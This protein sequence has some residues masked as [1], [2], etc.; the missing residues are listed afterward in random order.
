MSRIPRLLAAALLTALLL[1]PG[2]SHAA[3]GLVPVKSGHSVKKTVKRLTS[4]LEKRGMT[5]FAVIDHADGAKRAGLELPPTTVVLFGNPGAGTP[6]MQCARTMA[7]DLPQKMLV[8][9]GP[10][11][12]GQGHG[13]T[14]I[15]YN[16]P[17]YLARRHGITGCGESLRK[18][19]EAL[20]GFARRAAGE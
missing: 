16:D 11:E 10:S 13:Q 6:L 19:E 14:W 4:D 1:A 17:D 5:V 9:S 12:F 2:Q 7:I 18:I 8:F 20:A 15:V 3:A